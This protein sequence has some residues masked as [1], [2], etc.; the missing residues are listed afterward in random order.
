MNLGLELFNVAIVTRNIYELYCEKLTCAECHFCRCARN[1]SCIQRQRRVL[2]FFLRASYI[3]V[4]R[5]LRSDV[6]RLSRF[7][8]FYARTKFPNNVKMSEMLFRLF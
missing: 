6:R 8:P 1:G 4:S 7:L 2:H 5:S 3:Y